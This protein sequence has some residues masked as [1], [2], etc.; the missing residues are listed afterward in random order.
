MD[1]VLADFESRFEKMFGK[2]PENKADKLDHFNKNWK[3]FVNTAQFMDLDLMPG[4]LE[5]IQECKSLNVPIEILSS[6]SNIDDHRAVSCQKAF[7]LGRNNIAFKSNFVPG[8][9][10]KAEF[11]APWNIL[12]D[13]STYVTELYRAAG[14]TTI[15]HTDL[16]TTVKKLHELH[17]E[18]NS[19]EHFLSTPITARMRRTT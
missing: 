7:W 14:G 19:H 15:L 3:Q 6:T 2:R 16:N 9:D 10:K 1:G 4:A 11:A 18:W 13:D 17:L 5:L 12:I 8:G